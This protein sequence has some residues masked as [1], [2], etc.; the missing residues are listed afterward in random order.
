MLPPVRVMM[1]TSPMLRM[2][3]PGSALARLPLPSHNGCCEGSAISSKIRLML[4]AIS[5]LALTTRRTS[6]SS[7]MAYRSMAVM[8]GIAQPP[9]QS[10]SAIRREVG[11]QRHSRVQVVGGHGCACRQGQRHDAGPV[12][13]RG[14]LLV[15]DRSPVTHL[16]GHLDEVGGKYGCGREFGGV[17]GSAVGGA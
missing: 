15:V 11:R 12:R 7:A 14:V 2:R 16:G 1:K 4:A 10:R 6:V 3:C 13:Q 5:R 17:R 9:P 8:V